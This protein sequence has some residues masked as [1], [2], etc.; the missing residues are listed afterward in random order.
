MPLFG[1]IAL[2]KDVGLSQSRRKVIWSACRT[3]GLPRWVW[4]RCGKPQSEHCF[5]CGRKRG[6]KTF[7]RLYH[8]PKTA[9]W[10]GG[11]HLTKEGYVVV[12]L[13]RTDPLWC[14]MRSNGK[15]PALEH[16]VVIARQLG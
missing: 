12:T 15:A 5:P 6:G 4:L 8:G 2:A 3:C 14:M 16:R 1:D 13:L 11:R 9:A 7:S 10:N